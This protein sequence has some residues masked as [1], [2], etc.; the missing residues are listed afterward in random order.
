MTQIFIISFVILYVLQVFFLGDHNSLNNAI[1][2][3]VFYIE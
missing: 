2:L 3:L 1:R